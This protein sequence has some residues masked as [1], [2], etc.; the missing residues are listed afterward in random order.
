MSEI[1]YGSLEESRRGQG[2]SADQQEEGEEEADIGA[3][4]TD[5]IYEGQDSEDSKI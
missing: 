4:G 3:D 2:K 1:A 5:E